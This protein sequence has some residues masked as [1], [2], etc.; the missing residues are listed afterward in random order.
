MI[1]FQKVFICFAQCRQQV[2]HLLEMVGRIA[3]RI[4]QLS[5][6]LGQE[7]AGSIKIIL[8]GFVIEGQRVELAAQRFAITKFAAAWA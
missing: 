8:L 6:V 2:I 3:V 7:R 5:L 4:F 1:S